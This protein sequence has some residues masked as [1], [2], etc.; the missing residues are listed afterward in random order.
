MAAFQAVG[1]SPSP[2]AVCANGRAPIGGLKAAA[3]N[4]STHRTIEKIFFIGRSMLLLKQITAFGTTGR[5]IL[6]LLAPLPERLFRDGK[7]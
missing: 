2:G 4:D 1:M 6:L 3:G 7:M 5:T